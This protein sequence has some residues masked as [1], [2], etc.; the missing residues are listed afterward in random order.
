MPPASSD[1]VARLRSANVA[2]SKPLCNAFTRTEAAD[3]VV[4]DAVLP[5]ANEAAPDPAQPNNAKGLAAG[6]MTGPALPDE[7]A[8]QAADKAAGGV[9]PC[10]WDK[11]FAAAGVPAAGLSTADG[12]VPQAA[13]GKAVPDR[14]RVTSGRAAGLSAAGGAAGL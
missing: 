11:S 12:A 4:P 3:G 5:A 14:A 2:A 13:D 9:T 6:G 1:D 8:P 7:A 10:N